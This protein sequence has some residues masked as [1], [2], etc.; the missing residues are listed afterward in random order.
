CGRGVW[1]SSS[2]SFA[3][4]GRGVWVSSSFSGIVFA[5]EAT[6]PSFDELDTNQDG[7]VSQEEAIASEAVAANFNA[8]DADGDGL[9]TQQEYDDLVSHTG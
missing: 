7:A 1:V 5:G 9:L 8:A 2:F 6:F 3:G 4:C